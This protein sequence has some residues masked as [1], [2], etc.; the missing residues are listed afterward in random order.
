MTRKEE[1]NRKLLTICY[2]NSCMFNRITYSYQNE[3]K[4][5]SY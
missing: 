4:R 5:F 3:K 2:Y 1:N